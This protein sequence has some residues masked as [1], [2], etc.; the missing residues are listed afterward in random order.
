[1]AQSPA[2]GKKIYRQIADVASRFLKVTP[3][4][5]A[6][7][8]CRDECLLQAV[9]KRETGC[10]GLSQSR[11]FQRR[12]AA[13]SSRLTKGTIRR[14]PARKDFSEKSSTGFSKEPCVDLNR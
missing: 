10:P 7:I 14:I 1:M 4:I 12:L 3:S 2:E 11:Q 5:E 8:L 9:R 13:I 6:G